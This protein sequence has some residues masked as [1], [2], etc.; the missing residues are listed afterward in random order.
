MPDA[1][2][3]RFLHEAVDAG[4][5]G[6]GMVMAFH[7]AAHSP[8][9][10]RVLPNCRACHWDQAQIVEHRRAQPHGHIAEGTQRLLGEVVGTF[11][12]ASE[13]VCGSG[14]KFLQAPQLHS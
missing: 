13:L 8:E 9:R 14:P 6:S 2:P 1:I 7:R 5:C 11:Q 12:V 3:K 4:R 10:L